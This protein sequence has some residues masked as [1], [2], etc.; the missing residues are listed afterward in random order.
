MRL[1]SWFFLSEERNVGRL[2]TG[3]MV[4][5]SA[6]RNLFFSKQLSSQ[7]LFAPSLLLSQAVFDISGVFHSTL[8]HI[9]DSDSAALVITTEC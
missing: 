1:V 4:C 5:R 9:S 7:T 8:P 3:D 2:T 6:D